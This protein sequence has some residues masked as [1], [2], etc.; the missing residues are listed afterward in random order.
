[1]P[2][3]MTGNDKDQAARALIQHHFAVEP[4]LS[5][6]YRI[7][8]ANEASPDEPIKLL[9]VNAA[10]VAS[11]SVEVFGFAPSKS[12]PFSVMIAEVTPEEL[13]QLK[14][15]PLAMPQGW[16]LTR[17]EVFERGRAA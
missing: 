7:L 12:T 2:Y 10:T 11:G 13:E 14:A 8:S 9:E 1:M 6:V 3:T 5:A 16:S 15:N 4:E 17:A